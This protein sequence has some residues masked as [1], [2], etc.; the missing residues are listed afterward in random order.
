MTN[1]FKGD[2]AFGLDHTLRYGTY[3]FALIEKEY[4]K[5]FAQVAAKLEGMTPEKIEIGLLNT[6]IWAGL[7]RHHP[8]MNMP[9]ACDLIDEIGLQVAGEIMA[10]ALSAALPSAEGNVP[11]KPTAKA[12]PKPR[13]H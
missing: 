13:T 12:R 5:P 1:A 3:A 4:G 9:E 11:A 7:Q 2:V 8:E 10:E 6:I